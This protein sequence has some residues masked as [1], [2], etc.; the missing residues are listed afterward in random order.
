MRKG[1]YDNIS[2]RAVFIETGSFSMLVIHSILRFK[3]GC[4][5]AKDRLQKLGTASSPNYFTIE[6]HSWHNEKS[7]STILLQST[8]GIW[9]ILHQC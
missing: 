3:P 2:I 4:L 1:S 7:F 6:V 8:I 5:T 9:V